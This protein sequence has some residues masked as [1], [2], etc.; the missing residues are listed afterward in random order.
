MHELL[1]WLGIDTQQSPFYD[2]WSGA[3]TQLSV[4]FAAIT[5]YKK[6][7]CHHPLCLRVG[8]HIYDG[9]PYCTKH[10]PAGR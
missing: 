3:A 10:H 2:F 7:N 6:H 4:L 9:T 1:H 8:K 5:Y